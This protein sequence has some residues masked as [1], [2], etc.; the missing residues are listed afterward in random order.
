MWIL[1]TKQ[2]TILHQKHHPSQL[3]AVIINTPVSKQTD[4]HPD[5]STLGRSFQKD[6][7]PKK[8][9]LRTRR[10]GKLPSVKTLKERY[11]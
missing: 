8:H 2:Q 10:R 9:P 1:K 3:N 4:E 6:G 11:K 5:A 7:P